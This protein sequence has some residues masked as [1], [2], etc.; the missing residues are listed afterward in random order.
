MLDGVATLNELGGGGR[1]M[2]PSRPAAHAASGG[3]SSVGAPRSKVALEQ[4]ELSA[5]AHVDAVVAQLQAD[6]DVASAELDQEV[7]ML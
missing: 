1:A 6:P 5:A 2:R 4:H 3:D 7:Q